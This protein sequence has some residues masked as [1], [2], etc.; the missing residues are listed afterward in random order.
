MP[1]WAP[2]T[3]NSTYHPQISP[4]QNVD[5][6]MSHI[7]RRSPGSEFRKTLHL[8]MAHINAIPYTA[9]P[10]RSLSTSYHTLE[11][12]FDPALGSTS[13]RENHGWSVRDDWHGGRLAASSFF[14]KRLF[15]KQDCPWR[16]SMEKTRHTDLGAA[17]KT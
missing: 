8:H 1:P 15:R 16:G 11:K 6:L 3:E 5:V 7:F 9:H 12:L 13:L 2:P 10:R 4:W 17:L 14:R